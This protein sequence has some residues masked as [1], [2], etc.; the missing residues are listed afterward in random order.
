MEQTQ[1][2]VDKNHPNFVCKL[3]KSLYGLKQ[4]P[5]AW[6]NRLSNF[7]LDLGFTASLVDPSLFTFHSD[8]IKL[9]MLIYVD[10]IL[11]TGIHTKAIN[12]LIQHLQGEFPLKDLGSLSFFLS[13]QA[14]RTTSGLHL[15][16]AKYISDL[17]QRVHMADAKPSKSPCA[18][19]VKLSKFDG[20]SLPNPTEHRHVVGAL[21]YCTLN[22]S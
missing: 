7:L 12:S 4:A 6:F 8:S 11:L 9:F 13:I 10:D 17:L 19:G 15:C 20:T 1:G 3:H 21:Q 22:S 18:S 16:Q 14:T 5:R 2:F